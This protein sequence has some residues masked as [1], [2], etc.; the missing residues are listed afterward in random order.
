MCIGIVLDSACCCAGADSRPYMG[1]KSQLWGTFLCTAKY[2]TNRR[3]PHRMAMGGANLLVKE[4]MNIEDFKISVS[5]IAPEG[6]RVPFL[7]T[8][9]SEC[10][11]HRQSIHV[12]AN[13]KGEFHVPEGRYWLCVRGQTGLNPG[14]QC[15]WVH[16]HPCGESCYVFLFTGPDRRPEADV[17]FLARDAHYP[18]I[19]PINGGITFMTKTAYTIT[20]VNGVAEG[21]KLPVGHYTPVPGSITIPGYT[22]AA[23]NDFTVTTD[24]QTVTLELTAAGTIHITVA[25]DL[26][27]PIP[28]SAL[29]LSNADGTQAYGSPVVTDISG[30]VDFKNVPHGTD[31]NPI[32]LWINQQDTTEGHIRVDPPQTVVMDGTPKEV[33]MLNE[34]EAAELTVNAVDAIYPGITPI[35]GDITFNG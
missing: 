35:N 14:G 13:D 28:G 7:V 32:D 18:D 4:R 22:D 5:V 1:A 12:K 27:N 24:T 8:L 25:D 33:N 29:N 16:T 17:D 19:I 34:R 26:G 23:V 11:A 15:K 3:Q 10:R 31:G 2:C 6:T 20:F 9:R 30:K 21:V